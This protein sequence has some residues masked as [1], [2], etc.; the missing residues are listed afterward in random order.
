MQDVLVIGGGINGVGIAR[1][2]AGRGLCVTLCEQNDLASGTSSASTKLVHGGL[3]YLEYGDFM[4]VREALQE[5]EVLLRMA[6]HIIWPLRF[7]L[8]HNPDMR[9]AWMLRL[10]LLLYDN[11]GGREL[12]P[13]SGRINLRRHP[14]GA[15]LA[16]A[17]C[18]ASEYSDCWADD[19]RLVALNAVDAAER[20]ATILTRTRVV[21]AQREADHW[22]VTTQHEDGTEE[23]IHARAVVNAAGPWVADVAGA[24]GTED[25][26]RAVRLVKGSHIVTR[27]LFD[28]EHAYIFQGGDSRIVFAIAYERDFTLVGT[29]EMQ[30]A[31]MGD[32]PEISGD[33]QGYLLDFVRRHFGKDV[34]N[35]DVAWSYAGVRP[36]LDEPGKGA[37]A[38]SREYVLDLDSDDDEAPMLT[39]YGG[40]LTTYRTLSEKSVTILQRALGHSRRAW[41]AG[42]YLPGGDIDDADFDR[43]AADA[44]QRYPWL[45]AT[46]L[47][48][49]L[50]AYGTR[51]DRVLGT[52]SQTADLGYDFGHGLHEAEV[53]YLRS[54]EFAATADDVLWRRSKMGLRLDAA[55]RDALNHSMGGDASAA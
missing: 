42:S 18:T 11:L 2:A 6:P 4:L 22:A 40:K 48:R 23:T 33:E 3:R 44:G 19:S 27:R 32:K 15:P 31:S 39:V 35:D 30:H 5:R 34:A 54:R 10:G 28:G 41:T 55:G 24:I 13:P 36:L 8:P 53:E 14:A 20:G 16:N 29:T 21:A 52:A 1:D 43:F 7:V 12:L 26:T 25:L 46:T 49:L 47:Q 17:P 45:D 9:P 37:S 38:V 50:R 51:I